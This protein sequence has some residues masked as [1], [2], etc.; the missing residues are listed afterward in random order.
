MQPLKLMPKPF[1]KAATTTNNGMNNAAAAV[2][3]AATNSS[4]FSMFT[5]APPTSLY[6]MMQGSKQLVQSKLKQTYSGGIFCMLQEQ[7]FHSTAA[8]QKDDKGRGNG[9]DKKGNP[10]NVINNNNENSAEE[11]DEI[12]CEST[13]DLDLSSRGLRQGRGGD[14]RCPMCNGQLVSRKQ[15]L[16]S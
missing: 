6:N 3:A 9:K 7:N 8:I 2:V 10:S 12:I 1:K 14:I 11:G 16:N 4:T 13:L 15:T 5:T